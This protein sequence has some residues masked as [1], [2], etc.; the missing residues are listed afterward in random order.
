MGAGGQRPADSSDASWPTRHTPLLYRGIRWWFTAIGDHFY[1]TTEVHGI[2]LFPLTGPTILCFNHGNALADPL[3]LI[4]TTP[5]MVRFCAKDTLWK[6]PVM[7][8]FIRNSGAVPVH[9]SVEHGDKAK[10]MNLQVYERVIGCLREGDC[11]GFAPEGVSRFLPYMEPMLKT[12]V[13][14]IA[15][16][17]VRQAMD[18]GDAGFSVAIAPVCLN[19]THREKFRSDMCMRYRE[20]I[21]VD[22]AYLAKYT[23]P[24]GTLDSYAAARALTDALRDSLH[25]GTI[26]APDWE[27]T[28]LAITAARLHQPRGTLM[29]LDQYL[30]LVGGWVEVLGRVSE[31]KRLANTSKYTEG[32]AA[33]RELEAEERRQATPEEL[34]MVTAARDALRAYQTLLDRHG[35]KC[36]RVRR[37]T[38]G[39][40]MGRLRCAIG[41]TQRAATAL[42]FFAAAAAGLLAW[43]PVWIYLKRRERRLLKR[44]PRWNDSVAEM[45]MMVCGLVGM[46][47]VV[48]CAALSIAL[49]S[50]YPAL[51]VVYLYVTMRCYEEGLADARSALSH[52]KLLV[53][54]AADMAAMVRSRTR[55]KSALDPTT[56]LLDAGVLDRL[57][58]PPTSREARPA[59]DKPERLFGRYDFLPWVVARPLQAL[60]RRRK[61]DWNEVLRLRDYATM[62]YVSQ[63]VVS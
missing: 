35:I 31:S 2:E 26:N 3:M 23:S 19:F 21:R 47:L 10:D 63:S 45:K 49:R 60:L 52:Y 4:R 18:A 7:K 44:G 33:E 13:A 36:E 39:Q 6:T 17:A 25:A 38:H 50:V 12:G 46:A 8:H 9:R 15:I 57:A 28:R 27:T 55:A 48:G 40:G 62:D 5:R 20:P 22:A 42:A 56:A 32:T 54:D 59:P 34:R 1:A 29:T 58:L 53:L 51:L 61:C 30:T 24:S 41:L 11:L 16:E 37:A 43:S 14:R